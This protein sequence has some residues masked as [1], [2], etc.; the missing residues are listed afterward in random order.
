ISGIE[1]FKLFRTD[2]KRFRAILWRFSK[3]LHEPT[4]VAGQ[5]I[6]WN[7]P[8]LMYAWKVGPALACGNTVVLK[9]AEQTPLSALYVS[10][11]CLEDNLNSM[12]YAFNR[13]DFLLLA[14]T[15]S[16]E[17]GK[18]VLGLAAQCNL[19]P[20]LVANLLSLCED[21]NVDEA[22][23]LAHLALFYN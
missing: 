12:L 11:L 20:N 6:P 7:F 10:K 23:D 9:T 17:T 13:Q 22:V 4:G 18:I 19:K 1:R 2:L 21:V 5:I 16:T 3:T 8:L 15:G 14:F